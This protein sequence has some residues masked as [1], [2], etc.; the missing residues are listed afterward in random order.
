MNAKI[1]RLNV[2]I[3]TRIL[4]LTY[5]TQNEEN[6]QAKWQHHN[7]LLTSYRKMMRALFRKITLVLNIL[8]N[9]HFNYIF[10]PF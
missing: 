8:I 3:L 5:I 4:M 6:E 2:S 9:G 10:K 1:F 7:P